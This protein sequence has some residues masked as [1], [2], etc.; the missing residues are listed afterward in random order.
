MLVNLLD[1]L[2]LEQATESYPGI[3]W[4]SDPPP[5][6]QVTIFGAAMFDLMSLLWTTNLGMVILMSAML[7]VISCLL[8]VFTV[9]LVKG[10]RCQEK[11]RSSVVSLK[12]ERSTAPHSPS[13]KCHS[14]K[15]L[16][17]SKKAET[18]WKAAINEST[19]TEQEME[20]DNHAR[21]HKEKQ[22]FYS[23]KN[24]QIQA[25][26]PA[27]SSPTVVGPIAEDLAGSQKSID[28]W[29]DWKISTKD[30]ETE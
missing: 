28:F 21:L 18:N 5:R 17:N 7:A 11:K 24:Y 12:S 15:K 14:R 2:G 20:M 8:A 23:M 3:W 4:V 10:V 1:V 9:F 25:Q 13:R 29:W 30:S 22:G 6:S 16:K 27:F 19:E 26:K